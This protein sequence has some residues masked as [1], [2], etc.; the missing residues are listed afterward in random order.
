MGR[1]LRLDVKNTANFYGNI[2][3]YQLDGKTPVKLHQSSGKRA[4]W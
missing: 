4:D 3:I 2:N 1:N